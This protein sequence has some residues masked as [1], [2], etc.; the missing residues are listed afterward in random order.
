M[1]TL[2]LCDDY[3]HPARIPREGLGALDEAEFTFDWIENAVDWS[4]EIMM[5]YP[6]VI[7]TKSNNISS[8][9]QTGWMSDGVQ[10]DFSEYVRKGNGLL[11]IHSGTAE[12]EQKYVLR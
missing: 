10:A 7:L 6:V 11:A 9:N 4:P 1:K 3:W 12:H 5:T 2:V 8:T